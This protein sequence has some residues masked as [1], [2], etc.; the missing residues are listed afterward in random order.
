[1]GNKKHQ[2]IVF[3][4]TGNEIFYGNVT[5]TSTPEISKFLPH[6]LDLS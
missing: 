3:I 1:M 4:V 2:L 6:T 5:N